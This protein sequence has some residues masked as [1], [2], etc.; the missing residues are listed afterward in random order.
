MKTNPFLVSFI[1]VTLLV[2]CGK[3]QESNSLEAKKLQ[4]DSLK[5][6]MAVTAESIKKLEDEIAM[7][8]TNA[9]N[10]Q[11]VKIVS[12]STVENSTFNHFVDVTGTVEAEDNIRISAKMP[13]MLTSV[14]VK[15][16][17]SVSKGQL[18]A[19]QDADVI[20]KS[21]DELK[22]GLELANTLYGKQKALWDQ[23]IGSEVQYL[24]AKNQKESLEKRLKTTEAQLSQSSIYAPVSGVVEVVY[25]K[26]GELASPGVP[27]FQIVNMSNLK[28]VTN[29]PD[30]YL[31]TIKEGDAVEVE[32]PDLKLILKGTISRT[33]K[34][35][36]PGTRSIKVE[37]KLSNVQGKLRPNMLAIVKINDQTATNTIVL[38]E[39]IIQ[40]SEVGQ[41]VFV[42]GE[43]DG[44]KTAVMKKVETGMAYGGKVQVLKGLSPGDQLITTG[45]QELVDGQLIAN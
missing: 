22:N 45:Y 7:L 43:Q 6:V 41:I 27:I 11:K 24:Q 15:E 13:A 9:Q 16:G 34:I 29:V 19:T 12:T 18:L 2:A 39:N 36:D 23:K 35:V 30:A 10:E 4:L 32:L 38:Q 14:L 25:M 31:S 8:D 37:V 20:R 44:R 1:L 33:G 40:Q 3:K 42:A 26:E 21:I 17:Q 28:V 5:K